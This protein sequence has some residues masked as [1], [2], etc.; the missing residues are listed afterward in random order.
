MLN[1]TSA[2]IKKLVAVKG[3]NLEAELGKRSTGFA[4]ASTALSA[5]S[6]YVGVTQAR[7]HENAAWHI[8]TALGGIGLFNNAADLINRASR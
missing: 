8:L 1:I 2:D 7:K 4:V 6:I 3:N 5:G